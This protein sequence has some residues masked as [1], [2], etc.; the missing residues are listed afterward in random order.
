MFIDVAVSSPVLALKGLL[1]PSASPQA[2]QDKGATIAQAHNGEA[3]VQT[4]LRC[5]DQKDFADAAKPLMAPP[6][7]AP[8]TVPFTELEALTL[9]T[10]ILG[11][12]LG[13]P[14]GD[15]IDPLAANCSYQ[16]ASVAIML[17]SWHVMFPVMSLI[18]RRMPEFETQKDQFLRLEAVKVL[19]LQLA[20][21][22][23]GAEPPWWVECET[24]VRDRGTFR[25]QLVDT[26]LQVMRSV[27]DDICCRSKIAVLR[28]MHCVA[29]LSPECRSHAM[30]CGCAPLVVQLLRSL[31][32]RPPRRGHFDL[33]GADVAVVAALRL[34][35]SLAV[36]PRKHVRILGELKVEEDA[37]SLMEYYGDHR[38][39]ATAAFALLG[40]VSH[41]EAA[42]ERI[43]GE[44]RIISAAAAVRERWNPDVDEA[45]LSH[46]Q[47]MSP[48]ISKLLERRPGQSEKQYT[49]LKTGHVMQNSRN[50][51]PR[52]KPGTPRKL[53]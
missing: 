33:P 14:V 21:P 45:I 12:E 40:A 30:L 23:P 36:G 1:N 24:G 19:M 13:D 52:A 38:E 41:D 16:G 2:L 8:S 11:A 37:F 29:F 48:A 4:I 7:N 9:I 22:P 44:P 10:R 15:S 17:R 25:R 50:S 53:G 27:G 35:V 3:L 32:R 51:A 39:T 5:I 47:P 42:A 26:I 20:A 46:W 34:L 18:W 43:S 28:C 31:A 49:V 6:P